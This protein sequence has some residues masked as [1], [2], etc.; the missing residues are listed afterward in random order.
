MGETTAPATSTEEND[1]LYKRAE[2]AFKKK[3]YDYAR[4][5]FQ[6][7]ITVKPDSAKAR[8]ALWSNIRAL[9]SRGCSIVLTTHYLEEAEALA[10]RV[11]VL[12]R[13]RVIASGSVDEMRALVARRRISCETTLTADQ[14]ARWEGVLEARLDG[15]RLSIVAGDAEAVVRRLLAC[16]ATLRRLE[17]RE[18]GLSEAFTELTR[19]AA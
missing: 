15:G 1:P 4:D 5:L 8:E 12:A 16:D 13:G 18:A 6:Q 2:E 14:V 10:S 9:L 17:V 7:L 19:E 3:N 11:A